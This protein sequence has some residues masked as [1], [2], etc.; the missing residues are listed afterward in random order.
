MKTILVLIATLL[1]GACASMPAMQPLDA[2]QEALSSG[3]CR[4]HFPEGGWQL[5]HTINARIQGGRQ[6]TFTGVVILSPEDDSIRCA[7]MTLEGFVLFE[8]V[9]NGR[10]SVKRGFGPFYDENFAKG[11]MDDI[12]FLFVEPEG[13]ATFGLFEDGSRG[14]RYLT[15]RDRTVDLTEGQDGGWRMRQYDS[16]GYPMRTMTADAPNTDGFSHKLVLQ[17][18]GRH[19][20]RLTMTLVEAVSIQRQVR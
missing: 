18:A 6:A 17:A 15:G 10:V 7:V 1:L 16:L 3:I 13:D 4:S 19:G 9:D 11:V 2:N 12:R 5:V 8:S 14:C 20:Y